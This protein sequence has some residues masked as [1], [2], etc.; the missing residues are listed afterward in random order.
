M[1]HRWNTL[2]RGIMH[3]D[4]FAL[5]S[6]NGIVHYYQG[7][8]SAVDTARPRL[9]SKS[10]ALDHFHA[11]SFMKK[12]QEAPRQSRNVY[13]RLVRH[14]NKAR[15]SVHL[16]RIIQLDIDVTIPSA[17]RDRMDYE[18]HIHLLNPMFRIIP[19]PRLSMEQS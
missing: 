1:P 11:F 15:N 17:T 13:E 19:T 16:S 4:L 5:R 3:R 18:P 2:Y 10:Q 9:A 8:R 12:E 6:E 7:H 14:P